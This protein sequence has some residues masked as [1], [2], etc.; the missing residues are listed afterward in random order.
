MIQIQIQLIINCQ[1]KMHKQKLSI[2]AL[3]ILLIE[4]LQGAKL[5]KKRSVL[6][7]Q[8]IKQNLS[9]ALNKI[10]NIA[11]L[12]FM[13]STTCQFCRIIKEDLQ[14]MTTQNNR[15]FIVKKTNTSCHN[16]N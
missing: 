16:L 7:F 9:Q 12:K 1:F 4:M 11:S 15:Q 14:F 6:T 2:M 10:Y 5:Y 8:Q 3:K 13:Q